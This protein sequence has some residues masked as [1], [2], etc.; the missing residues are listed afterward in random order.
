LLEPEALRKGL[1]PPSSLVRYRG[2]VQDILDVEFFVSS[3]IQ[4]T[5]IGAFNTYIKVANNT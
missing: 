5:G 1:I 3:Y 4:E 2:M